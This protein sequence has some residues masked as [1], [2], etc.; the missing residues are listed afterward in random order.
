MYL[1]RRLWQR[2]KLKSNQLMILL[3][4]ADAATYDIDELI[5]RLE[6][7]FNDLGSN[8]ESLTQAVESSG[9]QLKS[10]CNIVVDGE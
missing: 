3:N 5:R 10:K 8:A 9:S 6:V 4:K 2:L 7:K 1:Y